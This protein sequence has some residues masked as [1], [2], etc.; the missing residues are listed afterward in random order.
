MLQEFA[1]I[2]AAQCK[3]DV[4]D[5]IYAKLEALDVKLAEQAARL[6]QVQMKVNL[7]CEA[8]GRAQQGPSFPA[9][10]GKQIIDLGLELINPIIEPGEVLP[11]VIGI[12]LVLAG[13]LRDLMWLALSPRSTILGT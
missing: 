12:N 3:I 1:E 11:N 8:I 7:S 13:E 9:Q 6:D 5:G 2:R 4:V 10:G